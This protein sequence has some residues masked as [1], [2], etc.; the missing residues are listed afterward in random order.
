VTAGGRDS[1][2]I[3]LHCCPRS[4]PYMVCEAFACAVPALLDELSS[5]GSLRT[6]FSLML[7]G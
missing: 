3:T 5:E 4:F 1:T 2:A 7:H 6:L